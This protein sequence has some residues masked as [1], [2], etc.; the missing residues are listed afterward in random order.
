MTTSH[1]LRRGGLLIA[2]ALAAVLIGGLA[3]GLRGALAS[4][5]APSPAADK[6]VLHLGWTNDPDSLNPFIGYESSSYEVWAINYDLLVGFRASDMANEP[7]IGL[8]QAW[9]IS[10]DGKVWTF[11]ITDKAKWQDGEPLTAADVAFTYNY[12]LE[13][14]LGMFIDY[15]KFIEKVEATDATHVVFT[16]SKPKANMLGLWIPI[17]PEHIWSSVPLK[18]VE[19]SFQNQPPIVGSGPFQTVEWK[20][21]AYVRMVANKD[22]WKGAPKIDEVI[23][24]TYQNSDTMAQDLKTGAL[25]TAWNIPGAQFEPLGKEPGIKAITGQLPGYDQ[26]GFNCADKKVYPKSTGH[27]VLQDPAFRS[28]LQWAVDNDKIVAVAYQ[29]HARAAETII[30]PDFYPEETDFHWQPPEGDPDTYTFD[31]ERAGQE[32]DAAGYT[33]ADGNGIRE[34][35]GEDI[36]LRLYARTESAESQSCGKL[37]T[38]WF[39]D[40]GIDIDYEVI[41]DGRLGD[42]QFAYD[43][44]EYAPDFD[45]FI[46]GWGGDIDPNF[47]LSIMTTSSIEAWSDCIWSNAEY[48]ELFLLQQTQVDIQQRVDT[49]RR[50]QQIIYEE[51]PY[52]LL[53]YPLELE[54]YNTAQWEGW[55]PQN[56]KGLVWYNTLPDTYLAVHKVAATSGTESGGSN[57]TLI[58]VGVVAAAIVVGVIVLLLVRRGRRQVEEA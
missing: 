21:G 5:D 36:T 17:L 45:L 53:V 32:L 58:I 6:T 48:D 40:V 25:Q 22:Y 42:L 57:T 28:A 31:L 54:A 44:D 30:Q 14:E 35:E 50:M 26:L 46:W 56:G 47:I 33:D 23:F 7:G 34:Y 38:G 16:C 4:S 9:E 8:A 19:K 49:V 18:T 43:G 37:I 52:I 2:L 10:P 41:D 13:N 24:Q 3:V 39:E 15:L 12:V 1:G 11:T 27:P 29:G 55:V 51:S 20:K